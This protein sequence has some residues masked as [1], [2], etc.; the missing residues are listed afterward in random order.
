MLNL[1][2]GRIDRETAKKYGIRIAGTYLF[3]VLL[4]IFGEGY[5]DAYGLFH[6]FLP[7]VACAMLINATAYFAAD[8]KKFAKVY[9]ILMFLFLSVD[10]IKFLVNDAIPY[11]ENEY[12]ICF[13]TGISCT[14][15]LTTFL[16][17]RCVFINAASYLLWAWILTPVSVLWNYYFTTGQW[18][19][20]ES[21]WEFK[22]ASFA[23][24]I[25][26][27]LA[28]RWYVIP[29]IILFSLLILR[30]IWHAA[31]I[32]GRSLNFKQFVLI[33]ALLACS[34]LMFQQHRDNQVM[35]IYYTARDVLSVK[36]GR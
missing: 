29:L 23:S 11:A 24:A 18:F 6:S 3:F 4:Q 31:K 13:C 1:L 2:K 25:E 21:Y 27:V 19:T 16:L 36:Y 14:L 28:M 26:Y 8:E 32:K 15:M 35:E 33:F 10:L 7:F 5:L 20:A 34:C 17:N 12:F 22:H 30:F 9:G